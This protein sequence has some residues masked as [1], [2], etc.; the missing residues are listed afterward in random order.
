MKYVLLFCGTREQQQAWETM[1]DEARNAQY[2]RVSRWFVE[3]AAK[4]GLGN[5]LASP[6]TATTVRFQVD[7]Q[8]IV[9]DGPFIC[10]MHQRAE[11]S[12]L[13]LARFPIQRSGPYTWS[14]RMEGAV[15]GAPKTAVWS[16]FQAQ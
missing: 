7:G 2:E 9:R 12:W 16:T 11:Q 3:N 4:I 10:Q 14:G 6:D 5:Q 13:R 15:S 1:T 8:P